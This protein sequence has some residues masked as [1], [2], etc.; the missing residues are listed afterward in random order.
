MCKQVRALSLLGELSPN[1]FLA[2]YWQ[3]KPLLVRDALRDY[4]SPVS[5]DELAGLAMEP[6]VESRLV[7]ARP[8]EFVW[9]L[10]QGPFNEADFSALPESDW[11]LLVQAVDLW[12]PDSKA[13]LALF[14][15]IPRW[16][17]DDLMVSFATPGGGVG[18]HIDQ[19]DVFLLQVEGE[20]E[21]CIGQQPAPGDVGQPGSTLRVMENFQTIEQWVLGPGDML[22]LPPNVPHWGT[23]KTDCL[24]FSIGFRSPSASEMLGDLAVEVLARNNDPQYR[25]PPLNVTMAADEI[26][27]EFIQSA[28]SVLMA[29]LDDDDLLADW[30]ARFMT[31]PKYPGLEELSNEQRRAIARGVLYENG[32]VVDK[33]D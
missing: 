3:Q 21:W 10:R 30:F 6:E 12:V 15:F 8:A 17:L 7:S 32:E 29:L 22:Y 20:R 26:A 5:P 28:K 11:S 25:D 1:Q 31:A 9:E 16:R 27:P 13:L 23:A 33:F 14:D 2:E 24:T 18:P 4:H 19:Y